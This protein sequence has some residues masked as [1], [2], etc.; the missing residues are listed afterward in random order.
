MKQQY[1]FG[2]ALD[3]LLTHWFANG[4]ACSDT[5]TID[6]QDNDAAVQEAA[7]NATSQSEG[8]SNGAYD[9]ARRA[10]QTSSAAGKWAFCTTRSKQRSLRILERGN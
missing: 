5:T 2:P 8:V 9:G 1:G 7:C 3:A 4:T 6:G 10:E